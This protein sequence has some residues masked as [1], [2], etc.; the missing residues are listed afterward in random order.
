MRRALS[1]LLFALGA[2]MAAFLGGNAIASAGTLSG[3]ELVEHQTGTVSNETTQQSKAETSNRQTNVNAPISILSPSSGD[4]HV[5]QGNAARNDATSG[6]SNGTSQ[7]AHQSQTGTASSEGDDEGW[8]SPR[9]IADDEGGDAQ[10]GQDQQGKVSNETTQ[11]SEAETS[12]RQTNVNAPISILSPSSGDSHVVQG[13]A[14]R[15]DATSG[16]SNGTGQSLE[17]GQTGTAHAEGDDEGAASADQRQEG[18]VRNTTDQSS[19]AKVDNEQ[20]NVNLP[21]SVLSPSSGDSAVIQRNHTDNDATSGN[22][23]GTGQALHQDQTGT[24][25]AEGD[26]HGSWKPATA[27]RDEADGNARLAQDQMGKVDNST[28]QQ[29]KA[30]VDNQQ[31]NTNLPISLLSPTAG[32]NDV[33]QGNHTDND[34]TSGNSNGTGQALH[35]DQTGTAHAEGDDHGNG[36]WKPGNGNWHD[37]PDWSPSK[38]DRHECR[39]EARSER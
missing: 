3:S 14:A 23:N 34:A 29:S 21:I 27:E 31:K 26:D 38:G 39:C 25:H 10:L 8:W 1:I 15:N 18:T 16:N 17:Q 9:S 13:N 11:E 5:V 20:R 32:D 12:S 7:T 33:I 30:R 4:S 36:T 37:R 35:Q 28:T 24:A 19:K 22:S 2:F 6:N